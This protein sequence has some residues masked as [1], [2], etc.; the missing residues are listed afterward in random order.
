MV[1]QLI[2]EYRVDVDLRNRFG[3]TAVDIARKT[4]KDPNVLETML[5]LLTKQS[6]STKVV[7]NKDV[8]EDRKRMA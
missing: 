8:I 5:K 4:I 6:K 1:R 2:N 7:H 3:K